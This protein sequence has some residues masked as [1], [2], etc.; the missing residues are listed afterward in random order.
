MCTRDANVSA[1]AAPGVRNENETSVASTIDTIYMQYITDRHDQ[2]VAHPR[3][4][5]AKSMSYTSMCSRHVLRS[6]GSRRENAS[7]SRSHRG[8]CVLYS[9]DVDPAVS[10]FQTTKHLGSE[11]PS[12]SACPPHRRYHVYHETRR[13]GA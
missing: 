11:R 8:S 3:F 7:F 2:I 12:R 5:P 10:P 9:V 4:V 1:R 6:S 13:S